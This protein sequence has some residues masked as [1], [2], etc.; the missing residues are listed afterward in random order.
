MSIC[1]PRGIRVPG[2]KVTLRLQYRCRLKLITIQ[3]GSENALSS[4]WS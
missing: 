3:K 2:T 1:Q 4:L